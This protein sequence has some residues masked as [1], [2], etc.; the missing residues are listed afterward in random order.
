MY[1]QVRYL[2]NV[3]KSASGLRGADAGAHVPALCITW[4]AR[5]GRDSGSD[6]EIGDRE[7]VLLD[8]FAARLDLVTHERREDI[9]CGHRVLDLHLHEPS[10]FRIDG[11]LPQLLPVHLPQA[12]VALDGLA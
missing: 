8:E 7:R 12:P 5:E 6:V 9:V 3:L 2:V 4:R 10:R 11:R 1:R